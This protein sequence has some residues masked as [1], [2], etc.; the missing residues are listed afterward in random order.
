LLGWS[1]PASVRLGRV[2]AGLGRDLE[3]WR[4][5]LRSSAA[6]GA[7]HVP[8]VQP[9]GS[10]PMVLCGSKLYLRRYWACEQA[11]AA[12][13]R[14]RAAAVDA[15]DGATVRP[16]LVRLFPPCLAVQDGVD[17]QKV[18]CAV[19]SRGRL[20]VITGGPGTGKTYAAAR[21][22]A[23]QWALD[24]APQR[25]RVALAAP[26]GKAAARLRQA[27]E[28]SLQGLQAQLGAA[29][30]VHDLAAQL[31]AARTLHSLLGARP[32]TRRLAFDT[33]H[34]LE[35]D[36][37]IVDEASMI[38]LEMMAA[39]LDALPPQAR[40]VLLGDKDQLAS[41]EAGAVLGDLCQGA[42][43]GRYSAETAA[44]VAAASGQ[45]LPAE[46]VTG[47]PALA[48]QTV[49]LRQSRRYGGPI[50][51]LAQAV[52]A[53]EAQAATALL[54]A[55]PGGALAWAPSRSAAEVVQL[56]LHGRA[57]AEVGYRAYLELLPLRPADAAAFAAWVRAVLTAFDR[58]RV[59]C[60]VREGDWGVAGLNLA[61]ERALVAAGLLG[62]RGEWYEGRPVMVTRNDPGVG[63]FNGDIGVVL[64][65]CGPAAAG[66]PLRAYFLDGEGV[67][68]VIV[69]RLARAETAFAMTVH[70]AQGSEFEHTVLV[71]P[72]EPSRVLT[73]ELVYTGI[74]RA[75][76]AFTLVTG[77]RQAFAEA[78]AQR[79]RRSS[80]LLER[81]EPDGNIA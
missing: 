3:H 14:R 6:V 9:G 1:L 64:R 57:G 8:A 29:L 11:V 37:L 79:T 46:F 36:L 81:L 59:L 66:L 47:G 77:R 32:E 74:T 55:A 27:I 31:G 20:A 45:S 34:P 12:Q 16:W 71:L 63:V 54:Q 72:Q 62:R 48:Q 33:A 50:G 56:A 38:H 61:I 10:P 53:G 42:G 7:P 78:L 23:L 43:L 26:T 68:S 13:L 25:L 69:S 5:V 17:W 58:F 49:M 35:L 67:R 21:L 41:V 2:I 19:A 22:L 18:A 70:K 40:I 52:N 75:R 15:I 30:P 76:Q 80:G 73:R 65:P 44:Y 24:P 28:A 39:L 51:R 4:A 60:A